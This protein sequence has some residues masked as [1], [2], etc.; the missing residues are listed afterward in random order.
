MYSSILTA[1]DLDD[2]ASWTKA[3]PVSISLA[4]CFS[5]RLTLCSVVPDSKAMLETEWSAIGYREMCGVAEARLGKLVDEADFEIDTRIATG[6]VS[7]GILDAAQ[8][9]GA[10]LI[11]LASHKP[12]MKDYLLGANASRVVRR[13]PCSVLVVR[14]AP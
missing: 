7:G 3:L 6:S 5:A 10:D 8:W 9:A 4:R 14:G 1:V 12:E 11:V 2:P 13:A